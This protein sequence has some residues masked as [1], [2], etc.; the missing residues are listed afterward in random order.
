LKI[1][2]IVYKIIVKKKDE[3]IKMEWKF[4]EWESASI[5]AITLTE[6]DEVL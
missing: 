4:K 5:V 3:Q 2:K 1:H 6:R